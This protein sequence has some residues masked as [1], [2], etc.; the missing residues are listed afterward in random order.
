VLRASVQI[1]AGGY[2]TFLFVVALAKLD[3]WQVWSASVAEWLPVGLPIRAVCIAVPAIEVLTAVLLLLAPATGL[4]AAAALLG[5]FGGGVLLLSRRAQGKDCGCFGT[6]LPSRIGRGLA[7]RN[8][9]LAALAAVAG[10]LA[11]GATVPGLSPPA[12][13][14][15]ALLGALLVLGGEARRTSQ[16]LRRPAGEEGGSG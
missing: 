3:G 1:I 16:L 12:I 13:L 10:L 14:L 2:A 7:V 6:L 11:G 8:L 4:L 15:F 5:V 9:L